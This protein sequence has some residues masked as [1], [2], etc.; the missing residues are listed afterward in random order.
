MS[1]G[2]K[3]QATS[4]I[5]LATRMCT[6]FKGSSYVSDAIVCGSL[7][8]GKEEVSDVDLTVIAETEDTR[9]V[10]AILPRDC[11]METQGPV[12]RRFYWKGVKFDV[13][14]FKHRYKGAALLTR[15]G[16]AKF[17]IRMR[18]KAKRQGYLL[19]EYGIH[20]GSKNLT[21][22]YTEE[23]LFRFLGLAYKEP[24]ERTSGQKALDQKAKK[25]EWQVPSKT[26]DA[27]YMVKLR[28]G[29]LYCQC[30][31]FQYRNKCWH[32][33]YVGALEGI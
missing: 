29:E 31:G 26:S 18:A 10:W 19:N 8:R 1:K 4:V 14:I 5:T 32:V 28:G 2:T 24:H 3:R 6:I 7:R 9:L 16:P 25:T 17:N 22:G 20:R 27:T 33:D 30:K 21:E 15:T 13:R 11:T 12:S 23:Q